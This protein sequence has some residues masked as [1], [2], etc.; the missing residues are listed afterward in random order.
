MDRFHIS[1]PTPLVGRVCASGAKNAALPALAASLLTDEPVTLHRIPRVR[2]LRTMRRLLDCLGVGSEERE[3][4]GP[5]GNADR[6]LPA[7]PGDPKDPRER[8]SRPETA[9]V[10]QRVRPSSFTDAPY[11][12]VKTMR[13]SVLVLGPLLAR[14]GFAR[15]SLPG[16]CAIGVRPIDQHLKGLAALGADV[17]LAGGYVET[18]AS[19]LAGARFRFDL[20]TVTGT[21]NLLLAACLARGTTV[22]E[23]C[24][25]EPEVADLARLLNAMGA[26][27]SGAGGDTV[28]I[29]GVDGLGGATHRVIPDRIEGG[30]YLIGAAITGGDV[31]LEQASAADLAPLLDKLAEVGVEIEVSPAGIRARAGDGSLR[32]RDVATAPHPGFPT[33]LQAQYMALMTRAAGTS[34]IRETVFENRFQHAPELAR[35]GARVHVDG[36]SA[37]VDGP[38]ELTGAAVM[39]TDLRA[40]ACLVLA[41]VAAA[42]TTVVDRIYH[43]DRGYE[44]MELKLQGLGAHVA[45]VAESMAT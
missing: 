41:G 22:L 19:R 30:T 43:L 31:L 38:T 33:D 1:G 25:R 45:R 40:S 36:G 17:K 2:D 4:R 10:L 39:A 3:A 35:M 29:D 26:R 20:P 16:G 28:V 13:A 7:D 11:E 12:L 18:R 27:I 21:E 24:A 5:E 44:G 34:T 32:A 9:L 15:V 23:N 6:W 42:G 37:R 14:Y 8:E